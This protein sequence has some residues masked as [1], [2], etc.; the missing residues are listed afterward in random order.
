MPTLTAYLYSGAMRRLRFFIAIGLCLGLLPVCSISSSGAT[1]LPPG[2]NSNQ[3]EVLA[4]NWLGA[5]G[6]G[7]MAFD[8]VNRGAH[9]RIGG[10]PT[11]EFL[12]GS[13]I[14]V[15]NHDLHRASMLFAE[16]KV[17]ML[18]VKHGGVV[19]F[20]VSWADNPVNNQTCQVTATARVELSHGVGHVSGE[21]PINPEPCGGYLWV[22]PIELGA[23]PQPNG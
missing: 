10:I 2:C 8:I 18:S 7:A 21:V 16:P 4:S 9:C 11:V 23:W 13:G 14:A 12:N 20:G 1:A 3:L 17:T 19:T 5:A 6:N 22:T 15:D